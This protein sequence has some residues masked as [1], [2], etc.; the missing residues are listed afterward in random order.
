[1][2]FVCIKYEIHELDSYMYP[3]ESE[4]E[5]ECSETLFGGFMKKP[6]QNLIVPSVILVKRDTRDAFYIPVSNL[7]SQLS[8]VS[9]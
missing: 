6:S 8:Y 1:M 2:K 3:S 4:L 5:Y 9:V 7:I